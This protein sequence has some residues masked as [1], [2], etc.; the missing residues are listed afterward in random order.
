MDQTPPLYPDDVVDRWRDVV[1][2]LQGELVDD[3]NHYSILLGQHGAQQVA[4][5]VRRVLSGSTQV[6]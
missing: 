3:V 2:Q 1:P 6:G 5:V 4:D